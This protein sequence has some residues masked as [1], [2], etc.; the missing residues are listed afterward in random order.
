MNKNRAGFATVPQYPRSQ[1]VTW[2]PF[3]VVKTANV[4][5]SLKKTHLLLLPTQQKI[6]SLLYYRIEQCSAAL[7]IYI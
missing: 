4:G 3:L 6:T 1:I 7:H 2:I 5:G